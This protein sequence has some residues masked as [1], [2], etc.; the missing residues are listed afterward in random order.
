MTGAPSLCSAP[1]AP[2]SEIGLLRCAFFLAL[3]V[4]SLAARSLALGPAG[5][6][7]PPA[8]TE[9]GRTSSPPPP[10]DLPTVFEPLQDDPRSGESAFAAHRGAQ[11]LVV[12]STRVWVTTPAGETRMTLLGAD[13]HAAIGGEARLGGHTNYVLG[14]DPARWRLSV[15][16]F[17]RVRSRSVYPGIDVVFHAA[18]GELEYD[19]VVAPGGDPSRIA[20][21]HEGASRLRLAPGGDLA[22]DTGA[23]TVV[24]RRPRAFQL[25][26]G[27]RV[28][29]DVEFVLAHDIVGFRIG[30]YD[31]TR[32]LL[33]DPVLVY[34]TYIGGT[35]WDDVQAIAVAPDGSEYVT[36]TASYVEATAPDDQYH[37]AST[38]DGFVAHLNASGTAYSYL[39]YFGG[40][41]LDVGR[42]IAVGAGGEVWVTGAT[43]SP[44]FPTVNPLQPVRGGICSL[45][46]PLSFACSDVMVLRIG[47][48]GQLLWATPVGGAGDDTGLGIA[49]DGA[50]GL[51]VTGTARWGDFPLAGTPLATSGRSFVMRIDIA[52]Q[53]IAYSTYLPG[54]TYTRAIAVNR[55]GEAYVAGYVLQDW[56]QAFQPTAT[57]VQR[58]Y[59][60]DQCLGF[61]GVVTESCGDALV[62]KLSP[63]GD[64]FVYATYLGGSGDDVATD[65]VV[66]ADGTAVVCGWTRSTDFPTRAAFQGAS[67]STT[68]ESIHP[69]RLAPDAFIARLNA[70]ATALDFSTYLGGARD[71]GASALGR[72]PDGSLV[73]VGSTLSGDFPG[74]AVSGVRLQ[75]LVFASD[76]DGANWTAIGTGLTVPG[77]TTVLP[78]P[79]RPGTLYAATNDGRLFRTDD[80]GHAWRDVSLPGAG[81]AG[82]SSLKVFLDA[83]D[84]RVVYA[85]RSGGL[86]RSLDAG[87]SWQEMASPVGLG[88]GWGEP[89]AVAGSTVYAVRFAYDPAASGSTKELYRSVDRGVTWTRRGELPIGA[90]DTSLFLTAAPSRP[91]TL[92]VSSYS[93]LARSTDGGAT[94]VVLD[95]SSWGP[96]PI[97]VHPADPNLLYAWG[98]GRSVDGGVAWTDFNDGLPKGV[99]AQPMGVVDGTVYARTSENG[100]VAFY[101]RGA[102][103][104]AWTTVGLP[105]AS[106]SWGSVAGGASL[107][108]LGG[109]LAA[110]TAQRILLWSSGSIQPSA[111]FLAR[112]SARDATAPAVA[113][114]AT[115]GE[116]VMRAPIDVAVDPAGTIHVGGETVDSRLPTSARAVQR[117]FG[118]EADGFVLRLQ[119]DASTVDADGDGMPDVWAAVT[120]LAADYTGPGEDPDHDGRTNL[121]EARA[122]THPRGFVRRYLAEG[123]TGALFDTM[124]AIANPSKTADAHVLLHFERADG[125]MTTWPLLVP[126]SSRRD[127]QVEG[128][129]GLAQAEFSTL[130]E[131]DVEVLVDR[132]MAWDDRAYGS[133]AE[134]AVPTPAT[135]WYFAEGA[136]HS[137]FNLFYLV[138]NPNDSDVSVTVSYLLPAPALP[139]ERSYRVGGHRRF[140]IWVNA[141]AAELRVTDVSAVIAADAPVVVERAM[142]LDAGGQFFGAGHASA[143]VTA[144]STHW[145]LAEGATG[146]FF[147]LFV[148]VANPQ[149]E[150]ADITA[151]F[152]LPEGSL[153]QKHYVVSPRS[154]FSIW[155]DWEDTRLADTA[156]ST[157]IESTNAIPVVVERAMWWPGPTP[158][159]WYEAHAAV[160]ATAT[161]SI[162]GF[163]DGEVGG[164]DAADTYVLI[165]NITPIDV[166]V[167]VTLLF[168]E[169]SP[170]TRYY[171]VPGSSRFNV[172]IA[173]EFPE[174]RD[175]TFSGIIEGLEQ[176]T[177][178]G[179]PLVI[180]P[181]LVVE[182][183]VYSN[184]GGVFWSAGGAAPATD[185][186]SA[187]R[188]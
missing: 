166:L 182:R 65:I 40:S 7:L 43:N 23:A 142:Y 97:I 179:A 75:S 47:A 115:G 141:E 137:G 69:Q 150:A 104:S 8:A 103:D 53:T 79:T 183:A 51:F 3:L 175:R 130:V 10:R 73:V 41:G 135:R 172:P 129:P 101:S 45:F 62:A 24:H 98:V 144:P 58:K 112:T 50:T 77:L 121:E 74:E 18:S 26:G 71:D 86:F 133:H 163:A 56:Q 125:A 108:A 119:A 55:L 113:R 54:E 87:A 156:V 184:S 154:R 116:D 186:G 1:R 88:G 2:R 128:L 42:D 106:A 155:V 107:P 91:D 89:F 110:R 176:G 68:F 44:D 29:V 122:G 12:R 161:S 188:R 131:S 60:G 140:T 80:G 33:I 180:R 22:V 6:A 57:V 165:A 32:P 90:Y 34:A 30:A 27:R 72:A 49:W 126:A 147:D 100:K 14:P 76:D 48:D 99:A 66:D 138:Q 105:Y 20:L 185:I 117:T 118:G 64:S 170:A 178:G 168:E 15:P 159:T 164:P 9:T 5:G 152:L 81:L 153:L 96:T 85:Q 174:A 149:P 83:A 35:G 63:G 134:R 46:G 82:W 38:A 158:A 17:A 16:H 151:T 109:D 173:S 93:G 139:V 167:S 171:R 31:R 70:T 4:P 94:F 84:N 114:V 157:T 181:A 95:A 37:S 102:T 59:G 132:R 78:S 25:R 136:T 169:G 160:G 162:W 124:V 39:T 13:A 111:V 127:V 61:R 120:G 92:Y 123:A 36:G 145:F 146:S 143:G 19:F 177:G 28:R 52:T 148:L 187:S 11:R 21:R 67:G